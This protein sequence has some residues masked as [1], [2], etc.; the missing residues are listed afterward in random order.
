M[1]SV[2]TLL[3]LRTAV[4]QMY[5]VCHCPKKAC[6]LKAY[7]EDSDPIKMYIYG[8]MELVR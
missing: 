1:L 6:R 5:C 4:F 3:G 2:I 7:I 8:F